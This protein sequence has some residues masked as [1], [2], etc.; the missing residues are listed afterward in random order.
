MRRLLCLLG[1]LYAFLS[2]CVLLED[3]FY[4]VVHSDAL[5]RLSGRLGVEW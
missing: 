5:W 1:L 3:V 4:R 2:A